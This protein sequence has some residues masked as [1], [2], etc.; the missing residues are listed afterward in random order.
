MAD[1]STVDALLEG[2]FDTH[3]HSAPDVL[4]RKF[5]DLPANYVGNVNTV[6]VPYNRRPGDLPALDENEIQ[7]LVAFLQTLT[8]GFQPRGS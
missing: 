8:D 2:A 6:E 1:Q 5:N 7:D 4:P 3:V